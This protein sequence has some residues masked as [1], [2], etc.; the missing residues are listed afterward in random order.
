MDL[1]PTRRQRKWAF[2][3]EERSDEAISTSRVGLRLLRCTRHDV[4]VPPG[5][6]VLILLDA[7]SRLRRGRKWKG[8]IF[9]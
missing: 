3:E 4:R 5:Y 1:R 7:L 2:S 6:S 9:P 8:P